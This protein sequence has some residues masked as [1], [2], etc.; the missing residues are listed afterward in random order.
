MEN[1]GD[2][3]IERI[4]EDARAEADAAAA[5]GEAEAARILAKGESEIASMRRENEKKCAEAAREL[6]ERSRIRGNLEARKFTL[7]KRRATVKEAFENTLSKLNELSGADRER[8]LIKLLE[9]EAEG[10]ERIYP[11]PAD[12]PLIQKLLPV[13]NEKLASRGKRPLVLEARDQS[14]R[15]GFL[16]VS[17]IYEKNCSFESLMIDLKA[18]E[19]AKAAKMLF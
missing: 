3:L 9:S 6:D 8:L 5:A 2:K 16:L 14:F 7:A 18:Q 10:G 4:I 1:N 17:D 15:G 13:I 19:E 12:R 11:A